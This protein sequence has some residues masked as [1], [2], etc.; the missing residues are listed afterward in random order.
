MLTVGNQLQRLFAYNYTV[1]ADIGFSFTY[2][3]CR[4]NLEYITVYTNICFFGG[5]SVF[6]MVKEL[7][8]IQYDLVSFVAS[9]NEN[10]VIEI[11]FSVLAYC[12][13]V[14][15]NNIQQCVVSNF[16]FVLFV[17]YVLSF[18]NAVMSKIP[19]SSSKVATRRLN[20]QLYAGY[21]LFKGADRSLSE[22]AE[23]ACCAQWVMLATLLKIVYQKFKI[24][25]SFHQNNMIQV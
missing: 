2:L 14:C 8:R 1:N 24:H 21:F 25:N 11:L 5:V 18:Y 13:I 17:K 22:S 19:G 16:L 10:Q 20:R 12:S 9:T 3:D 6:Y 15:N 23:W 4:F 7:T